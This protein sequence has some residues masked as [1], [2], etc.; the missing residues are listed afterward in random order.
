MADGRRE[1]RRQM[2]DDIRKEK[3]IKDR[4]RSQLIKPIATLHE[5]LYWK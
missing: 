2:A 1:G 3:R 5:I 4:R